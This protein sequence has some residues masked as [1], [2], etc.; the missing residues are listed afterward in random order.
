MKAVATAFLLTATC[1]A[2]IV[3]IPDSEASPIWHPKGTAVQFAAFVSP[4]FVVPA[5]ATSATL[6][7]T[8]RQS[9]HPRNGNGDFD[10]KLFGSYK[11]QANG[12]LVTIGPGRNVPGNVQAVDSVDLRPYVTS[13]GVTKNALSVVSYWQNFAGETPRLWAVLNVTASDG[14]SQLLIP[15]GA[16]SGGWAVADAGPYYNPGA[17]QDEKG[18]DWYQLP[19][20]NLVLGSAPSAGDYVAPVVQPPFADA[21]ALKAAAPP[22]AYHR[23]PCSVACVAPSA[24]ANPCAS[25]VADFGQQVMGGFALSLPSGPAVGG[26]VLTVRQGEELNPDGSVTAPSRSGVN[27]TSTITLSS[28]AAPNGGTVIA[29]QHEFRQWR[30][31]QVSGWPTPSGLPGSPADVA[32]WLIAYPVAGM[33]TALAPGGGALV[34]VPVVGTPW[35]RTCGAHASQLDESRHPLAHAARPWQLE[36]PATAAPS[37]AS[38]SPYAA[39]GFFSSSSP[40][41]DSVWALVARSMTATALDV[42][43]DSQTR[44]R[45]LCHVDAYITALGQ[46]ALFARGDAAWAGALTGDAGVA[47]LER[48]AQYAV[49][50]NS[51]PWKTWTEF[52]QSA[53]LIAVTHALETGD[54][55]LAA[56]IYDAASQYTTTNLTL[57]FLAQVRYFS[58]ASGL[59]DYSVC[60]GTW[61]CDPLVDWPTQTRD[62]FDFTKNS[63][64]AVRN[65]LGAVAMDA[66]SSVATALGKAG[67]AALYADMT[68][69]IRKGLLGSM[70][71]TNASAGGLSYFSDGAGIS[72]AAVHST[73]Y[74]IAGGALDALPNDAARA[75]LAPSLTAFLVSK[76]AKSASCMTARWMLEALYR[77]GV[78]YAPA[79][80]AAAAM[81]VT[82]SYPGWLFME[83]IGATVTLEAWQWTDKWNT[84]A[85]HPW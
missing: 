26:K 20:E 58:N 2:A 69:S 15:T 40:A 25:F 82:P 29:S 22:V 44:Q 34:P 59:L 49:S 85:G 84:D 35:D 52:R 50:N 53:A 80:E 4:G 72:H 38:D 39:M 28:Q 23:I 81:M 64:D 57:Q 68:A 47:Y 21:L 61:L 76:G 11:L 55:A 41:L 63:R 37:D 48:S 70:L 3:G 78:F 10:S 45:D 42:N 56:S 67:D 66:L 75:A 9:Q 14:S 6:F 13:D 73:I 51:D 65:G 32:A 7:I 43:V 16:S 77:L 74:A 17:N 31:L 19:A 79:A 54:T 36:K 24:G 30:W 1:G 27:Y 33:T 8:S 71:N 60:G 62:G 5:G 83:S 18:G 46:Y 12:V